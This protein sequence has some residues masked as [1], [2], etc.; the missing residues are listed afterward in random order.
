[1]LFLKAS[2]GD[3]AA[4]RRLDER[5]A[6]RERRAEAQAHDA[7]ASAAAGNDSDSDDAIVERALRRLSTNGISPDVDDS[8]GVSDETRAH[9]PDGLSEEASD[10]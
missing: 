3:V 6:D 1:M 4:A 5:R 7:V 2:G 9:G 10:E 8:S